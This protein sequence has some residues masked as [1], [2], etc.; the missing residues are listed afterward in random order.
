[1][2]SSRHSPI[3]AF[4]SDVPTRSRL[5]LLRLIVLHFD[6]CFL[7]FPCILFPLFYFVLIFL[8]ILFLLGFPVLLLSVCFVCFLVL[9]VLPIF[10]AP[11][12][13]LSIHCQAFF[14]APTASSF[15]RILQCKGSACMQLV[16]ISLYFYCFFACNKSCLD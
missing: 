16:F 5:S 8:C 1:V 12:S 3:T 2:P 11:V 14:R 6:L 15:H 13:P 9:T 7:W 10:S 4:L